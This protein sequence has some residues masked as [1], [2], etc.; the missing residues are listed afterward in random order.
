MT[1]HH[2]RHIPLGAQNFLSV[3]E[4]IE[5]GFAIFVGIIAGLYFQNISHDLLIVTGIIGLIVNAFNASAVR[6]TSEHFL[7]ELDGH[8]KR[9]KLRAYLVPAMVE[10]ATYAFVSLIAVIP[11]LLVRDSFIAIGLTSFLTV[12]ILYIAGWYRGSLLGK[13]PQR[14]GVE[15]ATI[16][17]AI[18]LVGTTAGWLLAR[19]VA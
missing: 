6:Y 17:I 11:L 14:D 19:A 9:Q 18:I 4:G 8:E 15:L 16:G 2:P 7:D 1:R 3:L 12:T 10:F 13:H 5:G